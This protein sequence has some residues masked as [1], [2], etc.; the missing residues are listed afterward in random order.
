MFLD[1]IPGNQMRNLLNKFKTYM[2]M[3]IT[4]HSYLTFFKLQQGAFMF[5]SFLS[6]LDISNQPATYIHTYIHTYL[7]TDY[8]IEDPPDL[9][10]PK[11]P[12][13]TPQNHGTFSDT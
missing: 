3:T 5:S 1:D 10:Y 12:L 7:L 13:E 4:W 11:F 8:L 6:I 2:Q 9:R